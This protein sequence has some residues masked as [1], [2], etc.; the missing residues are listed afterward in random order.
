VK[1]GAWAHSVTCPVWLRP[2]FE[3]LRRRLSSCV[4][5]GEQVTL[6]AVVGDAAMVEENSL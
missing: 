2:G 5:V 6:A 3:Q 1:F 4:A